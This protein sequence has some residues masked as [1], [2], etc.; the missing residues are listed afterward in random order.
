MQ[1]TCFNC[2]ATAT[3]SDHVPPMVFFPESKDVDEDHR[4]NLITAPACAACNN[5]ASAD[6]E[7]VAYWFASS[8]ATNQVAQSQIATKVLRALK[9][10][11]TLLAKFMNNLQPATIDGVPTAAI[12][13]DF[14]AIN[15]VMARTVRGLHFART[16]E[17]LTGKL[18]AISPLLVVQDYR[19]DHWA[20]LDEAFR[21]LPWQEGPGCENPQVF[22]YRY[23]EAERFFDLEFYE[24]FHVFVKPR[25]S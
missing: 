11:P 7:L 24:G 16:G 4:K 18:L 10:N 9:R 22:R 15:R 6:D 13:V 3:T 2:G 20:F 17:R 14:D 23:V 5:G 8:H 12:T 21:H 25:P 1:A 19:S